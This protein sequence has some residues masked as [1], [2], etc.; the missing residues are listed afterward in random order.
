MTLQT[1]T[2]SVTGMH[3]RGC[4]A[5]IESAVSELEGIRSVR[6]HFAKEK[7]KVTW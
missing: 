5:A 6:A 4:E 1:R 7:V 3:C 2:F